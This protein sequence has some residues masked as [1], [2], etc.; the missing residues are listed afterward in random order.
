MNQQNVPSTQQPST[1][2]TV[3]RVKSKFTSRKFILSV[4]GCLTGI[5]GIIGCNDNVIAVCAF[6]VLEILCILGFV[7]TEGKI[8]AASVNMAAN[9]ATQVADI[10]NQLQSGKDKVDLPT[11][12]EA[13]SDNILPT[14]KP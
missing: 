3:D 5:L 8:D 1:N 13:V 11:E 6:V 7:I 14:L 10:I 4:V 2:T 12:E 9:L